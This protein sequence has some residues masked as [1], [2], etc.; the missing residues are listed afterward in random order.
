MD[1]TRETIEKMRAMV[2]WKYVLK[3]VLEDRVCRKHQNKLGLSIVRTS[4]GGLTATDQETN[5]AI[6]LGFE[7]VFN[8][9]EIHSK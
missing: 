1:H 4:D 8:L 3:S 7:E 2:K 5:R 9:L 6:T